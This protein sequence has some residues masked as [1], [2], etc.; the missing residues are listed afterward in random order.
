MEHFHEWIM[1]A[2][3]RALRPTL[4]RYYNMINVALI[5][6]LCNAICMDEYGD[7]DDQI[8]SLSLTL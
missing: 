3:I 4:F 1:K 7:D 8:I 6:D 2:R 5:Y